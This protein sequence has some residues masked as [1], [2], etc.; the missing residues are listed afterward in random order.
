MR[1]EGVIEFAKAHACGNDFLIVD[2][3]QVEGRDLGRLA[4]EMCARTTGIGGDGMEYLIKHSEREGAIHLY[5]AD[6]TAAELSGNGTRCVAAW[7]AHRAGLRAGDAV[8]LETGAG[9]RVCKLEAVNGA[10][11]QFTTAMGVPRVTR[12]Q[13]KLDLKLNGGVTVDAANVDMGNPQL[14]VMVRDEEFAVAGRPWQE[15]GAAICTHSD[16]PAGT[17]VE[18]VRRLEDDRIE[19]RIYERGVGPT[20]SSGTGTSASAAAMMALEGAPRRLRVLAPGGEQIVEWPDE[21]FELRLTGPAV[22]LAQ[23]QWL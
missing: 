8:R 19:I 4:R 3:A 15:V 14:I 10:E 20:S 17:N 13:V 2:A 12:R 7:M 18:F 1:N 11:F 21:Q 5:N 9:L 23:G 22:V 16:F 6:G